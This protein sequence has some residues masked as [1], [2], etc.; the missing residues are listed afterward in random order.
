MVDIARDNKSSISGHAYNVSQ[1][2]VLFHSKWRKF[3]IQE[4]GTV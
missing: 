4:K 3:K 1:P 2:A